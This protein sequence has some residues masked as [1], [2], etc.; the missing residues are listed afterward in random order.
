MVCICLPPIPDVCLISLKLI[1]R[2]GQVFGIGIDRVCWPP[3]IT[4]LNWV[5]VWWQHLPFSKE[6]EEC[7]L[8]AYLAV[9]VDIVVKV[10]E[11]FG[12]ALA[13]LRLD[14]N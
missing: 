9:V 13:W 10:L 6:A 3:R 14:D 2:E 5:H 7:S 4:D 11:L 12:D 1:L 8:E